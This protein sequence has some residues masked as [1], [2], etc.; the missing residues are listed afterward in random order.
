MIGWLTNSPK[1]AKKLRLADNRY[2]RARKAAVGL[3]LA[4]KV[5]AIRNAKERRDADYAAIFKAE[6]GE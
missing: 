5:E 1:V 6:K 2:D 3:K 4:E